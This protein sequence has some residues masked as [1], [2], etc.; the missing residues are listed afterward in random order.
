MQK[1]SFKHDHFVKNALDNP[2]I[3]KEV[4]EY[5]MPE[6]LMK[7]L[8]MMS[9]K[10]EKETFIKPDLEDRASDI[11]FSINFKQKSPQKAFIYVLLEH[12]SSNDKEM[13]F[14]M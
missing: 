11:I 10:M 12:Q 1:P 6:D 7:K 2:E 3:A 4:L 8:D 5:V 14:R 13:A 9:I